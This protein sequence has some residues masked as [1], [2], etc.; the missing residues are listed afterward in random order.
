[1]DITIRHCTSWGYRP[2]AAGLA[3]QIQSE[4]GVRATLEAGNIGE[5][6]V[7]CH[8]AVVAQKSGREWPDPKK[9]VDAISMRMKW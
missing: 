4:L 7:L 6:T 1:M 8:G 5:F 2:R 3:S 9:V